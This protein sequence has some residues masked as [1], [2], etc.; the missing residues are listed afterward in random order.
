MKKVL[1]FLS[2]T[3]STLTY[4]SSSF[5]CGLF[6]GIPGGTPILKVAADLDNE[7]IDAYETNQEEKVSISIF[8][9]EGGFLRVRISQPHDYDEMIM[10]RA[11]VDAIEEGQSFG[12]GINSNSDSLNAICYKGNAPF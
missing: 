9:Q 8:S 6:K 2:L 4:A 11:I 7:N 5:E 12:F 10:E 1:L 3:V